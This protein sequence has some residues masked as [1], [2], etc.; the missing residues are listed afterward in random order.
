MKTQ[1][2]HFLY[3]ILFFVLS[4]QVQAAI[5]LSERNVLLNLYTISNGDNWHNSSNWNGSSGSE[6]SWYGVTCD[7]DETTVIGMNLNANNLKGSLPVELINLT[8]LITSDFRF[9]AVYSTDQ[10][11]V[12]FIDA[13]GPVGSLLDTQTLDATGLVFSNVTSTGFDLS[14]NPV[15]YQQAGGYRVY[16]AQQIDSIDGTTVTNFVEVALIPDKTITNLSLTDLV[17]CR[18]YFIKV[19]SYTNG[20]LDNV[21]IIESDGVG[22]P[23]VG[24]IPGFTSD[25]D[26]VGSQ[27]DD[28]FNIIAGGNSVTAYSVIINVNAMGGRTYNIV[29]PG[30]SITIGSLDTGLGNDTVILSSNDAVSVGSVYTSGSVEINGSTISVADGGSISGSIDSGGNFIGTNIINNPPIIIVGPVEPLDTYLGE[31]EIAEDTAVESVITKLSVHNIFDAVDT[32]FTITN[33]N[34]N[35]DFKIDNISRELSLLKSL[36]YESKNRYELTIDVDNGN[37]LIVPYTLSIIVSDVDESG[38]GCTLNSNASFDPL[39]PFMLLLA[40]IYLLRRH[41]LHVER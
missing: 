25:C 26:L 3:F 5:P 22:G 20:H 39:F 6:C 27:Y 31:F 32:V 13:T 24:T 35:G 15:A 16:M 9:N 1:L 37:G 41:Y 10:T 19:V 33:G 11:L 30:D 12:D 40:I 7:T 23:I 14:W 28:T 17:S 21:N 18:Q 34:D 38:G 8:N 4:S 2:I 29:S 36:D